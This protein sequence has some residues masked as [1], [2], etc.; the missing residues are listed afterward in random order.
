M[1]PSNIDFFQVIT[2]CDYLSFQRIAS[3][4]GTVNLH[5]NHLTHFTS[6]QVISETMT[7]FL[8]IHLSFL[9]YCIFSYVIFLILTIRIVTRVHSTK[10]LY[11]KTIPIYR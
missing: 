11:I 10:R 8:S 4:Y 2:F 5:D 1:V 6:V 3:Q 9:L 7:D